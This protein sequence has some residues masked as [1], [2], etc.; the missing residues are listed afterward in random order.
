M[1]GRLQEEWDNMCD[2][3]GIKDNIDIYV[4]PFSTGARCHSLGLAWKVGLKTHSGLKPYHSI[5]NMKPNLS[6]QTLT[7]SLCFQLSTITRMNE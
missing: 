7:H 4:N 1:M 3:L 6:N 5:P 2:V